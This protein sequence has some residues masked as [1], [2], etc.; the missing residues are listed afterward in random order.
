MKRVKGSRKRMV[1]I[2]GNLRG[3]WE[4]RCDAEGAKN[5]FPNSGGRSQ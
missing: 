1:A 4:I 2:K 5:R 3:H